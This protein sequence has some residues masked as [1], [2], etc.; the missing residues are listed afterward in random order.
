MALERNWA[1]IEP[2][3]LT[4][5]GTSLGVV[6]VASTAGF[7]TKMK[8]G[9]R[10]DTQQP[11]AYQVQIVLS[12]T[13][14]IVGAIGAKVGRDAFEDVSRFTVADNATI[15]AAEQPKNNIP[16][17]DHYAA[18]YE[19]DPVVADRNI[20]VDKNGEFY[21]SVKDNQGIN[22]LAVD[23]QFHAE[24]DVQVD[25]DVDGAYDP[26]TNPD[27]DSMANI[28]HARSNPTNATH[29]TQRPTAKRGTTDT[30]TVSSDVSIHD[31]DGN[32]YDVRNPLP[33]T[34][35]FEKFFELIAASKW[36][37]LANYDEVVPT[38]SP[39]RTVLTLAYMEDGVTIGEAVITYTS[40]DTWS[41][42]LNRYINED[43]GSQLLDDDGTPLNLD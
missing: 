27:P 1:A 42:K 11:S 29:Q 28:A 18:V 9:L 20:L 39:D 36:M 40:L 7:R 3:P 5:N 35:G 30:D 4:A 23:G 24:V 41:L 34:G 19:A 12:P 21:G 17:K 15:H 2:R 31:H 14:M 8:V 16:E 26:T 25:V 43:D 37:E 38:Y 22:R 13:Q 6:T 33:T 10:S 32:K